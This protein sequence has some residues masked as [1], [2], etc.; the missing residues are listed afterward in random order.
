MFP[1]FPFDPQ[2]N[3]FLPHQDIQRYLE[4]YCQAHHI[5]PHIRVRV[6]S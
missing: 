3:S 5:W 1:D 4:R 2:L 6:P